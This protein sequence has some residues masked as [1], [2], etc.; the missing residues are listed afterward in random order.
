MT[1]WASFQIHVNSG[2]IVFISRGSRDFQ[3]LERRKQAG[4]P[5]LSVK[6]EGYDLSVAGIR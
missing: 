6:Y 5:L 1:I 3:S 2:E 4:K